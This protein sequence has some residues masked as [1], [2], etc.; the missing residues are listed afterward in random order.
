MRS[1]V[2]DIKRANGLMSDTGMWARKELLI[3]RE[4]LPIG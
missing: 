4:H 3:P 1:Q 2:S